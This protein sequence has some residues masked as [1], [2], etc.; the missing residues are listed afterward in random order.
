MRARFHSCRSGGG[1]RGGDGVDLEGGAGSW[2][3]ESDDLGAFFAGGVGAA[4]NHIELCDE[5]RPSPNT[6]CSFGKSEKFA[7]D[8][9]PN[10]TLRLGR[11]CRSKL[12]IDA[13]KKASPTAHLSQLLLTALLHSSPD[14]SPL[15]SSSN[16]PQ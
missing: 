15:V 6:F 14:K 13:R 8:F 2:K 3:V 5:G 9:S 7:G 1:E 12:V 16:P 11:N 10:V 4:L